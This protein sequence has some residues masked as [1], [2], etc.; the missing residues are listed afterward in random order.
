MPGTFF[1]RS[2]SSPLGSPSA[3]TVCLA[4]FLARYQFTGP[5]CHD[6]RSANWRNASANCC[7]SPN[8]PIGPPSPGVPP[9]PPEPPDPEPPKPPKPPESP[10]LPES[11]DPESPEPCPAPG[12]PKPKGGS[13]IAAASQAGWKSHISHVIS[14]AAHGEHCTGPDRKSV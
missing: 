12:N 8:G 10:E 6:I 4:T 9:G 2:F 14:G 13:A 1:W 5:P 11:P 3:A 7:G